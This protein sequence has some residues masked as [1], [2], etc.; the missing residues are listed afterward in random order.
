M[1]PPFFLLGGVEPPTKKKRGGGLTEPQF[2]E[3]VCWERGNDLFQGVAV[4]R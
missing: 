3:G 2:L 1:H 4:F